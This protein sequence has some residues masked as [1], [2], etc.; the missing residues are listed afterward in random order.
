MMKNLAVAAVFAAGANALVPRSNT[1]CFG[2]TASGSASGSIGQLDDGQNRIGGNLP[3]AQYCIDSAG[4]ITDG[5]G[6]GCIL[7]PPTT[8]F[9]CDEGAKPTNGFFIDS[10]GTVQ[11][12]GSPKFVACETG[13]N[14]GLN[15]YT[16]ESDA[17]TGC[18]PVT[19]HAD[20]C[21]A[22]GSSAPAPAPASSAPPSPAPAPESSAPASPAPAPESSAPAS[23][24]SPAPE[25]PS[26][27][28]ETSSGCP[29]APAPESS[30]PASPAPAPESSAPASSAP[31]PESSAPASPAPAPESSAPPSGTAPAPQPS[32][33]SGG[34]GTTLQK[35]N[36]EYPHLIIPVDSS[37]P[38]KAEGTSY[39]GTITSTISSIFNFDIPSEDSGKQCSLVFL[40][41]KK[42]DLETSS[43]SFSG[44]GKLDFVSLDSPAKQSTSSSNAPG[45]KSELGTFTVAPGNNYTISTFSCPA[46][47]TVAY[48]ISNAGST[49]LNYFQDYNPSPIGLYI[50]TC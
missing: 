45:V 16:T 24:V 38:D 7:T 6:R 12:N 10:D 43:F 44:D 17:Q 37:A 4:G 32:S 9:Q 18:K 14:G 23:P 13:E 47:Q 3:P 50:I 1:C 20:S 41:P 33:S 48:E 34:C 35:G 19:L 2:L 27:A 26:P 25:Q 11:Y 29:S 36:Y 28:P 8:Q 39:N 30:A 40:F 31:A 15:I 46:G 49:N 5:H 42:E 21:K 22:G